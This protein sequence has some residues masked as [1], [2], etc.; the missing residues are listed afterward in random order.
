[1][2]DAYS[3]DVDRDALMRSLPARCTTRTRASSRGSD[4]S[5]ARSRPTPARSAAS[6]RTSSRCSPTPARTRSRTATASRLRG[7]RRAGRGARARD[8][9][10]PAPAEPMAKVPTPGQSTCE[11]VARAARPAARA[12]ASSAC[13]SMRR[14]TRADAARARRSHGQRSQD[15]QAAGPRTA[16]AGRPKPRSSRRPAASPATSARSAFRADMPLIV[17]RSVAVMS[18][19][20]CGANERGL[21][22]ARRQFR[23]R[24]PRAGPSSPTSATSSPATRRPTARARSTIVRGIEVGHVFALGDVYSTGDGRNLSRRRA[25]SRRSI[26]MGCYG[27]GV[28][29]V[30]AAAI[31]QNHDERGIVWPRADGAV[32]RGDR[33]VGYDRNEAVRA[34]ADR[35]H[36]ELEAAGVEVLLDDR[37]ERP[38]V[39][40]ADLELIG[41][42]HRVTIGD[43]GLKEGNVE[44]QARRDAAATTV[45][46]ADIAAVH[47]RQRLR[48]HEA[49]SGMTTTRGIAR[50]LR[51]GSRRCCARRAAAGA[52]R[53]AGRRAARAVGR[54]AACSARSPTT[55]CPRDYAERPSVRR[56]SPRCRSAS[57]TRIP[58]DARARRVPRH[59]PLRS[60]ARRARSAARAR[61]DPP[62]ERL[63]QV[64]GLDRRR[65]RLHAGDA[66]LDQ[67]HRRR[68]SRTSSTCAPTCATAA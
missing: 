7:E 22:P 15:R 62:R 68:R 14:T 3:F 40:F 57:R 58:D 31:E 34:A 6:R 44:Y 35:L 65:A 54:V 56:G 1:M 45:P 30:V 32:R 66:V 63:Q 23:P 36:D 42:P 12:H 64:R 38:G 21:P 18:D 8:R 47:R 39:M 16:G 51:A 49:V 27:I 50:G 53:R 43:R 33:A 28:T 5:S 9:R 37:G 48:R 13:W 52:R 26:E 4:S 46:V 59:R 24:L 25:V 55:P 41:I 20:V 60:D 11:D 19:F 29:R 67:A 10:A 17:D 61:R 2:K